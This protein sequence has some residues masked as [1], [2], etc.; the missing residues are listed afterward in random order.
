MNKSFFRKK[1]SKP[2]FSYNINLY[3]S[4]KAYYME[5]FTCSSNKI[6]RAIYEEVCFSD[7][8][9]QITYIYVLIELN[10]VQRINYYPLQHSHVIL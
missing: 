3:D 5:T 2:N 8:E 1:K 9:L 4:E 6:A 10:F 7:F